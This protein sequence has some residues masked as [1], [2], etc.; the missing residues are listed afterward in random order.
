M[1]DHISQPGDP[2]V[3]ISET[4]L[5]YYK[6]G[7]ESCGTPDYTVIGGVAKEELKL[8]PNPVKENLY[9]ELKSA[10]FDELSIYNVLGELLYNLEECNSKTVINT[11]TLPVGV[12]LLV[13]K[14]NNHVFTQ[15][16]YKIE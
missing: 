7:T 8:Y 2:S 4:R 11:E 16:V 15:K 10:K 12:Y 14:S 13:V 6:K 9:I 3:G 5:F 1:V